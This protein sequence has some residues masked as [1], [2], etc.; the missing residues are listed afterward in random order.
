V[1][2]SGFAEENARSAVGSSSLVS[3]RCSNAV[4]PHD[5]VATGLAEAL[6][7]WLR[8][9]DVAALRQALLSVLVILER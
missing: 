8:S 4:T 2:Q 1:I 9:P 3:F 5:A 6:A 7:A